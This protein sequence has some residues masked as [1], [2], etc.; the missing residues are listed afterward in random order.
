MRQRRTHSPEFKALAE[1]FR[2]RWVAMEAVSGSTALQEIAVGHAVHPIQ[3]S[4]WKRQLLDGAC[5][6]FTRVTQTTDLE[7][8]QA[9]EAELFQQYCFAE[10]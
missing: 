9:K 8:A 5:K 3:P 4:P 10:A 1:G 6:L 2:E 7:E